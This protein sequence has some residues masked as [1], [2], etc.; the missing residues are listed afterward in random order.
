[1]DYLN[2]LLYI[3]PTYLIMINCTLDG[4]KI[5]RLRNDKNLSQF[6]LAFNTDLNLELISKIEN[7]RRK[8]T[9]LLTA[10]KLAHFF[11][12]KIEDLL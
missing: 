5:R 1:L 3:W 9:S 7:N 12:C 10:V 2:N 11:E 6:D 8:N 4:V